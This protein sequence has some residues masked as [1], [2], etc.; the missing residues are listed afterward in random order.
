M[1]CFNNKSDKKC[2]IKLVKLKCLIRKPLNTEYKMSIGKLNFILI[3]I[4]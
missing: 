2:L 1:I 3:E 4:N